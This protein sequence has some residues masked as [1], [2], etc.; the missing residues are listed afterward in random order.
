MMTHVGEK[1]ICVKFIFHLFRN[2]WAYDIHGAER[3]FTLATGV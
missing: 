1:K 3:G 2:M